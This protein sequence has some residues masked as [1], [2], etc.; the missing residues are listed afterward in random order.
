MDTELLSG[1]G[2]Q[3]SMEKGD[4]MNTEILSGSGETRFYGN[5]VIIWIWLFLHQ[6]TVSHH[7]SPNEKNEK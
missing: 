3:D 1:S 4:F 6:C 2:E 7:K 5:R